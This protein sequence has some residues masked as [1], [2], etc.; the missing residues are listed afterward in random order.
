[1]RGVTRGVNSSKKLSARF[2]SCDE[3]VDE[4]GDTETDCWWMD[5]YLGVDL[6]G[7]RCPRQEEG[8]SASQADNE[9]RQSTWSNVPA[10]QLRGEAA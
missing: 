8:V 7:R 3:E 2:S 4:S 9:E 6:P 10:L 5:G 1:M